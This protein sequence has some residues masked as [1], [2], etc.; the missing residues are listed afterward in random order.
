MSAADTE[1]LMDTS[2]YVKVPGPA[3]VDM[4]TET[5]SQDE[6]QQVIFIKW[7]E[8][9][10]PQRY[11]VEL[12]KA[13]QSWA[14]KYD[15]VVD[16]DVVKASDDEASIKIKPA[17]VLTKLLE[18]EGQ[19]LTT[20][21]KKI[22]TL[23]SVSPPET[24]VPQNAPMKLPSP[25]VPDLQN[26]P[27][28]QQEQSEFSSS[29]A[30][31]AAEEKTFTC[32]VPIGHY[33]YVN[34]IYKEKIDRIE[35][36]NGVQ[37]AAQMTV[38]LAPCQKYGNIHKAYDEFQN[39]IQTTAT[40]SEGFNFPLKNISP[41]AWED[42]LKVLQK[43][44]N[45]AFLTLYSNEIMVCGPGESQD[46]ISKSLSTTIQKTLT[47]S[48][49]S[50]EEPQTIGMSINDPLVYTGVNIEESVWG[51]MTTSFNDQVA[52]LKAKFDVD[53]KES[54][55]GQGQVNIKAR[56]RRS[57]QNKSMESHAVR[58]LLRLYQRISTSAQ[59]LTKRYGVSGFK[60]SPKT[61]DYQPEGASGGAV[62]NGPPGYS[63]G[64]TEEPR[65]GAAA[66]G[67]DKDVNCP[68]CI[69]KFNN[70]VQLK[71]KHEFCKE[72]LEEAKKNTGP[73]CP[74]CKDVFG[75]V[76]GNQPDGKMTWKSKVSSLKGF[77]HCGT[78]VITYD[79]PSGK[80]TKRH[81]NP[82]QTYTGVNR[83]AYLPDNSEGREVLHLLKKAFDQKLIFTVG[84]SRTTG[85]ENQVTWNDIHH[86]TSLS[87]GP[88]GFGYPDPAY[89]IRVKEEL[90]A[91]G[92]K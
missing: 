70:K 50:V 9:I 81:P 64:D 13:L 33:W 54:G 57:K 40:E 6:V 71:C 34:H 16:F 23:V 10:Q 79:I 82:G 11:K 5:Q 83:E 87:G 3:D 90:K 44:E 19:T 12:T 92:I 48:K 72:C 8:A 45:K 65:G 46:A 78:I 60:S 47:Y 20:R 17:S 35:K 74:V 63:R 76:E 62:S 15:I 52:K 18:A 73:V 1:E 22:V 89:L 32:Y 88:Q 51:L 38:K 68:I 14:N 30:D 56:S 55:L 69:D 37:I 7:E 21:N 24:K 2:E 41:E 77:P 27:G 28:Q 84:T 85:L 59:G 36:E 42:M 39:L 61:N 4:M 43:K 86:K 25:S 80:Q 91:K 75:V 58:A 29:V 31:S 53:F 26:E 67:D 49:P 66:A